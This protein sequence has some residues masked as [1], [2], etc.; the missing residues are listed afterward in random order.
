MEQN[1]QQSAHPKSKKSWI[2]RFRDRSLFWLATRFGHLL[3]LLAGH[4]TRIT[5]VGEEHLREIQKQG[6][7]FTWIV[8]HGR[9]LIPI[10]QRRNCGCI[11][12][13]S[14]HQDGELITRIIHKIGYE[15][16]RGSSTRGGARAFVEMV[17]KLRE[18]GE[19]AM[20]PDGPKGPRHCFKP[21][22]ML[23]A[24]R[25]QIPM[26]HITF[27]AHPAWTFR[28]WD[29]FTVPKPFSKSIL[30]M[31]KPIW[32]NKGL[33]GAEFESLRR[34]VE[35]RMIEEVETCDAMVR[36]EIPVSEIRDG[37]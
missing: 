17:K 20:L 24:Q 26:L 18:G 13:V 23:L 10:F 31:G 22:T 16:S 29:R 27:S 11:A 6:T 4:W 5:V 1:E 9:M 33:K 34:D 2:R 19:G 15:T 12:M 7:G 3:L 36:G 14:E 30:F 32:V 25:A 28:S 37:S 21:G 8:W 35:R